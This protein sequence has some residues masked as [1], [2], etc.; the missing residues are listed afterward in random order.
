MKFYHVMKFER[1]AWH[2]MPFPAPTLKDADIIAKNILA[3]KK[4]VAK[5]SV[6]SRNEAG[7]L[8][9]THREYSRNPAKKKVVKRVATRAKKAPEIHIDINSHNAKKSP[10]AKTNPVAPKSF[11]IAV[12]YKLHSEKWYTFGLFDSELVGKHIASEMAK[13]KKWLATSWRVVRL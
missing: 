10:K 11:N 1:G 9:Q 2:E 7:K 12:Q 3:T 6:I 13:N 5:V 4:S 8:L